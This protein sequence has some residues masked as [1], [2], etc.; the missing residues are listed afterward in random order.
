MEVGEGGRGEGG[1]GGGGG[2]GGVAGKNISQDRETSKMRRGS[3]TRQETKC[4]SRNMK[5]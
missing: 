3:S 4:V 1:G 2:G 5:L